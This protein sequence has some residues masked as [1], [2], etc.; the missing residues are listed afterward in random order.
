MI[1]TAIMALLL[2]KVAMST[3]NIGVMT[4]EKT[5]LQMTADA[6]AYSS[7]VW[8]ARFLNHCAYTRR[9]IIANNALIAYI[10]AMEANMKFIDEYEKEEIA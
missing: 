6:A 4:V 5:R 10:T 7:A 9:A 3:Y 1:L 8:Q 2:V